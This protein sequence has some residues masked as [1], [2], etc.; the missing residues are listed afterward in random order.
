MAFDG[1]SIRGFQL[2]HESDMLLLPDPGTAT[3]DPFRVPPKGRSPRTAGLEPE[4]FPR[5]L[6]AAGP[7]SSFSTGGCRNAEPELLRARPLH[8][9]GVLA[10]PAQRRP[11]SGELAFGC[12]IFCGFRGTPC[13]VSTSRAMSAIYSTATSRAHLGACAAAM[14]NPVALLSRRTNAKSSARPRACARQATGPLGARPT[15]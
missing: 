10:R 5:P 14:V 3:I 1:S 9:R 2:I 4:R 13:T 11:Q 15:A 12:W 7:Y 6:P 8:S